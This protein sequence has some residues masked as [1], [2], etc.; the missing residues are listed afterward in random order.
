MNRFR[1]YIGLTA[2]FACVN[3]A[4]AQM[5]STSPEVLV[6]WNLDG[7]SRAGSLAMQAAPTT[8]HPAVES[9]E[10]SAG[11]TL[12][13]TAWHDA[14]TVYA[15]D[16]MNDLRGAVIMD[17]YYSFTITPKKGKKI[18]YSG[19]FSRATINTGN[20]ETGASIKF[21]LMS[22]IT[23]FLPED[24]QAS[25]TPLA[26]FVVKHPAQNAKATTVTETFDV[27]GVKALQDIGKSVEFRIYAVLVDGVG[28]RMGIGHIFF[29]DKKD[30][31]RVMGI[32]E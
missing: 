1:R 26:S 21:V 28:N 15:K 12:E 22:S 25:L 30:D 3:M 11:I 20:L 31:L 7:L 9:S 23:G 18:S 5:G 6:N 16:L 13:P 4:A 19:I 27:S 32:V 2:L 14:L 10:L 29:Q 8:V 17:H 24:E